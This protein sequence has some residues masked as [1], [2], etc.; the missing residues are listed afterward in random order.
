MKVLIKLF[1][2]FAPVGGRVAPRRSPQRA[3]SL[4]GT[5]FLQSRTV[6]TDFMNTRKACIRDAAKLCSKQR[7]S[8]RRILFALP[9]S[10]RKATNSQKGLN[11]EYCT[12]YEVHF[13]P[14]TLFLLA[15]TGTK[16]KASQKENA[17]K[18]FRS[19]RRATRG[20]APPDGRK[21]P[22]KFDQNFYNMYLFILR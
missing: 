21:L 14:T 8:P 6:K 18:G 13:N 20:Y 15:E 9:V 2:K 19:L 7:C 12:L 11:L 1:Q 4:I 16:E 10:K 22:T 3:K 17:E 5:F